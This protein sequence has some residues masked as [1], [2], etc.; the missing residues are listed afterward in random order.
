MVQAA[1]ASWAAITWLGKTNVSEGA[2]STLT[3]DA[4]GTAWNAGAYSSESAASGD[5]AVRWTV[6]S[7]NDQVIF[8]VSQQSQADDDVN[9]TN[10]DYAVFQFAN[11]MWKAENSVLTNLSTSIANSDVFSVEVVGGQVLYKK[12]GATIN[13]V[14]SPTLNYPLVCDCSINQQTDAITTPQIKIG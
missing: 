12:N 6:V 5:I 7:N 10:I 14:A 2:S 11:Q 8:G 4:G 3:K 1:G 9:Y 13:T